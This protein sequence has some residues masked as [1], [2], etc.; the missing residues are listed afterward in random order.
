MK[1]MVFIF[2]GAVVVYLLYV[3]YMIRAYPFYFFGI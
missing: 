3:N 1:Y 2:L